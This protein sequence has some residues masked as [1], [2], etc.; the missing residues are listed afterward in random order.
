MFGRLCSG[1]IF[2]HDL[3]MQGL[4]AK[5]TSSNE[6]QQHGSQITVGSNPIPSSPVH[7][8]QDT[9]QQ[10]S[11]RTERRFVSPLLDTQASGLYAGSALEPEHPPKDLEA[12]SADTSV[13]RSIECSKAEQVMGVQ[14]GLDSRSEAPT[15]KS[16]DRPAPGSYYRKRT[17]SNVS[18]EEVERS[19]PEM[20]GLTKKL[21]SSNQL[22]EYSL[23]RQDAYRQMVQNMTEDTWV[24]LQLISTS[25][26][27]TAEEKEL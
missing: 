19:E 13:H 7:E 3:V 9:Q 23:V 11:C 14:Q 17:F 16:C 21:F 6:H 15:K 12:S 10:R 27:Y 24:P 8:S 25:D 5:H 4:A 22:E 2:E 1:E 18:S 26:E 20:V